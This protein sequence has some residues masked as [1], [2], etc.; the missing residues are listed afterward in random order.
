MERLKLKDL[1]IQTETGLQYQD[2]NRKWY[3]LITHAIFSKIHKI[4]EHSITKATKFTI[5]IFL[6]DKR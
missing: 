4:K 5:S 3:H 2:F 1:V 6:Y